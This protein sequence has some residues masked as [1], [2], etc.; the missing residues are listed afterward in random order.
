ME[1]NKLERFCDQR[2]GNGL[3]STSVIKPGELLYRAEPFA[4]IV[5]KK[6]R[7]AV[8]EGCFFRTPW[9][10]AQLSVLPFINV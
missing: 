3:R 7:G 4:C 9:E 2:K 8:C 5:S 1:A 6:G 10:R